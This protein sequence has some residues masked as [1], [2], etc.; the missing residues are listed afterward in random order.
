MSFNQ[1]TFNA[2]LMRYYGGARAIPEP[3]APRSPG[4]VYENQVI[5]SGDDPWGE[6]EALLDK[7]F[8]N[9]PDQEPGLALVFGLGLGYHLKALRQRYPAVRLVVLE[10]APELK[11]IFD[12][13][14]LLTEEDGEPPLISVTWADFEKTARQEIIHGPA[15][16][17]IVVAP[18]GY[19]ALRPDVC[20]SFDNFTRHE[21]TRRAVIDRT[22]EA[23]SAAFLENLAENA[24]LLSEYPDLMILKGRLPARPAFIVGSGPSL[25]ENAED[26]RGVG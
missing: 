3:A 24:G 23:T 19:R 4:L 16:A 20:E 18:E 8:Q 2:N 7:A 6:A 25:D 17:F 9:R 5:H 15:S 11:E 1:N 14:G 26:L 12:L 10:P 21:I 22:R 13:N